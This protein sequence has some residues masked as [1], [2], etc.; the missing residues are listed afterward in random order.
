[1]N[2]AEPTSAPSILRH[3]LSCRVSTHIL[4]RLHALHQLGLCAGQ[5]S[6]RLLI[7]PSPDINPYAYVK[8]SPPILFNSAI[9]IMTLWDG[10]GRT[11][12][13]T[14]EN[15]QTTAATLCCLPCL[16]VMGGVR[17]FNNLIEKMHQYE[18]ESRGKSSEG[19]QIWKENPRR[20]RFSH[21]SFCSW[22]F[23]AGKWLRRQCVTSS[24]SI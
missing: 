22:N 16:C 20:I 9:C 6:M 2:V 17:Y 4:A 3:L 19:E 18:R 8:P 21:S 5:I 10:H 15:I 11:P 12:H 23:T 24:D 7:F 1:M 14:L 13:D